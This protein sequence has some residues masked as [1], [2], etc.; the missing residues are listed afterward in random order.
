MAELDCLHWVSKEICFYI[1]AAYKF[2]S[3]V[4]IRST[5]TFGPD[6]ISYSSLLINLECV[7]S[8]RNKQSQWSLPPLRA[9]EFH[10]PLEWKLL[11]AN[12]WFF[13][14]S[15]KKWIFFYEANNIHIHCFLL[16]GGLGSA[17]MGSVW[18]GAPS[19]L[20]TAVG[21]EDCFV[22]FYCMK[23][24]CPEKT[25]I[26]GTLTFSCDFPGLAPLAWEL[27]SSW[28]FAFHGFTALCH[29]LFSIYVK[30]VLRTRQALS[31]I[32]QQFRFVYLVC[33][34]SWPLTE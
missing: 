9:V 32:V 19:V 14:L 3:N 22:L 12:G 26:L 6:C 16:C 13:I 28:F 15:F 8:G 18:R 20:G 30:I 23:A 17:F 31:T 34:F 33:G 25:N 21:R 7:C 10:F 4:R 5:G 29:C 2:S 1:K 27:A 24:T 11:L